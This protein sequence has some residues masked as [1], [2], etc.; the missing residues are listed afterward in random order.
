MKTLFRSLIFV[1]CFLFSGSTFAQLELEKRDSTYVFI[2]T[3]SGREILSFPEKD[4]VL[5]ADNPSAKATSM[6]TATGEIHHHWIVRGMV[7]TG[8]DSTEYVAGFYKMRDENTMIFSVAFSDTT[9]K[10]MQLRFFYADTVGQKEGVRMAGD[11]Y[12]NT[13]LRAK[14]LLTCTKTAG[15]SKGKYRSDVNFFYTTRNRSFYV[16]S[17]LLVLYDFRHK[18]YFTMHINESPA[19]GKI[20]FNM[21]VSEMLG[22]AI[23]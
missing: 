22:K 7:Y 17:A 4:F 5:T 21:P 19:G 9:L 10:A 2:A 11:K 14:A 16:K 13:E 23:E 8:T 1:V 20:F 18:D 3:Q 15:R 6:V 12:Q